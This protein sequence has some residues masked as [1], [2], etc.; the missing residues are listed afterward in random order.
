[1][2]RYIIWFRSKPRFIFEKNCLIYESGLGKKSVY[3]WEH[4]KRATPFSCHFIFKPGG[5]VVIPSE[6]W[7]RHYQQ[8]DFKELLGNLIESKGYR[9]HP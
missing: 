8:K 3:F 7:E 6:F 9:G 1:M 5:K 2:S 4:L